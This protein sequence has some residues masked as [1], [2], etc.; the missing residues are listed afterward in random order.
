MRDLAA[1]GGSAPA[2]ATKLRRVLARDFPERAL[3]KATTA[4]R[5]V[6]PK[7]AERLARH[8]LSRVEDLVVLRPI[9]YDDRRTW[10]SVADL[11][12]GAAQCFLAR[13]VRVH[14]SAAPRGR[15]VLE[16]VVADASGAVSL[17]WFR[18]SQ[19]LLPHIEA[20]RTLLVAGEVTRYRYAK[21]LH[22]PEIA[23]A[24]DGEKTE[25]LARLV[26]LYADVEGVSPRAMR[27][28]AAAALEH[29]SDLIAGY[30]PAP[31]AAS[32]GL[33]EIG[34]ALRGLH[35]PERHV[36]AEALVAGTSPY[37]R[38]LAAEQLLLLQ[39]GL[40]LRRREARSQRAAPALV[41]GDG[42][43]L[44]AIAS[45][46]AAMDAPL[47]GVQRRAWAVLSAELA[48]LRPMRRVLV[49]DTG[50]GQGALAAMACAA[51]AA[52][53]G[54]AVV[55]AAS[56][57]RA[58]WLALHLARLC[59][60][61]VLVSL[62][63][64]RTAHERRAIVRALDAKAVSILVGVR[65]DLAEALA[66]PR[67]RLVVCDLALPVAWLSGELVPVGAVHALAISDGALPDAIAEAVLADLDVTALRDDATDPDMLAAADIVSDPVAGGTPAG[68]GAMAGTDAERGVASVGARGDATHAWI[69]AATRIV[70]LS[71]AHDVLVE[72]S[73]AVARGERSYVV[74]PSGARVDP[75]AEVVRG[76]ERLR[77]AL[78]HA[79]IGLVHERMSVSEQQRALAQLA[80][81]AV[82]VLAASARA[83]TD[84]LAIC[85][86]P[87]PPAAMVIV[88]D[89]ERTDVLALHRL[90]CGLARTRGTRVI[91]LVGEGAPGTPPM[92]ESS[93]ASIGAREPGIERTDPVATLALLDRCRDG[94]ELA[95]HVFVRAGV[96]PWL[97]G[98][99]RAT[100]LAELLR[101]TD[102]QSPLRT[103]ARA[104]VRGGA[105]GERDQA[106]LHAALRRY[107]ARLGLHGVHAGE[108][109]LAGSPVSP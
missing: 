108:A 74:Y 7:L 35:A 8:G 47:R 52:G 22:E 48:G 13:V 18:R 101:S 12:V 100:W 41:P 14:T 97:G 34:R 62:S 106:R 104:L 55:I 61:T 54:L 3:A 9:G 21:A 99:P 20:G 1:A 63:A 64:A 11:R 39:V 73:A 59:A 46:G 83:L 102:L 24:D 45:V 67:L 36:T 78:P 103:Y 95:Q 56:E 109:P 42:A 25:G 27:A 93:G 86:V 30:V 4:V 84:A 6:G 98:D 60:G 94:F 15:S 40:A 50:M 23:P 89:A 58:A 70:A 33:P 65:A 43:A 105:R 77:R 68:A 79:R 51:T 75:Q 28:A 31:L 17:K 72:L 53:G 90:R 92:H 37:H 44:A 10:V 81:S 96:A 87:P 66:S 82:D 49:G 32:L 2:V 38:R 85:T 107:G 69:G 71:S 88:R 16:A 29:A 5:G 76:A 57:P 26:P 19:A 91:L 80:V